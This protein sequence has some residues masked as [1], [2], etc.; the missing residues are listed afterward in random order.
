MID[1][2]KWGYLT[3]GWVDMTLYMGLRIFATIDRD[4]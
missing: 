3:P 1:G 2:K 4:E